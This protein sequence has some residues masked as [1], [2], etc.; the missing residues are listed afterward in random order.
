MG[1]LPLLPNTVGIPETHEVGQI[2]LDFRHIDIHQRNG[3]GQIIFV[4]QALVF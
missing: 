1:A 2:V 3:I 4:P